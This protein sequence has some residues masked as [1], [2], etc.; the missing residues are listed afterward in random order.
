MLL[1][2]SL[3]TERIGTAGVFATPVLPNTIWKLG[4]VIVRPDV[5]W[6]AAIIRRVRT[7][8]AALISIHEVR[9]DDRAAA[10]S[11][12]GAYV[13]GIS[14]DRL[15]MLNAMLSATVAGL[16]GDPDR[17]GRPDRS[18]DLHA[19]HRSVVGGSDLRPVLHR[20]CRR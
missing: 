2:L 8:L 12:K 15:A 20:S 5:F 7:R 1:V 4:S 10:E 18:A 6:L 3:T 9:P 17:S 13:S 16:A 11:E 19:I 14:P